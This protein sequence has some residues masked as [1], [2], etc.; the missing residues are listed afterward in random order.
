MKYINWCASCRMEILSRFEDEVI[1]CD[2]CKENAHLKQKV[3]EYEKALEAIVNN[4]KGWNVS[5]DQAYTESIRI[6]LLALSKHDKV[7]QI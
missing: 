7:K 6:A 1:L 4:P 2:K 3:N 5:Y